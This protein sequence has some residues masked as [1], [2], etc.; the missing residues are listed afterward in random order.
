VG[1]PIDSSLNA[2]SAL[3]EA[4]T[5]A[6]ES[7]SGGA[8]PEVRLR[9]VLALV[10]LAAIADACLYARPGGAGAAVL[11]LATGTG[12]LLLARRRPAFPMLFLLLLP[13][14][15]MLMWNASWLTVLVAAMTILALALKLARADAHVTGII[16]LAP[17]AALAAPIS[18]VDHLARL[19]QGRSGSRTKSAPDQSASPLRIFLIPISVS[20]AFAAI[21]VA[22]NPVLEKVST[23]LWSRVDYCLEP[24]WK[25]VT[26]GRVCSWVGWLLLFALLLRPFMKPSPVGKRAEDGEQVQPPDGWESTRA[27]FA[28]AFGTLVCVNVLFLAFNGMDSIYLYFKADLP[29]GVAWS[30]YAHRGCFWLTLALA[31]STVVIDGIFG[32]SMTFHARSRVLRVGAYVWAFQNLI[33]A[34]G[35]FRRLQM[36]V[37]YNGLTRL[38]VTGICGILLVLTGLGVMVWKVARDRN[39]LWLIRRYLLSSWAALALLALT[40]TDLL[41]WGHNVKQIAGGN[42][43]PLALL[44]NQKTSSEAYPP[45]LDLLDHSEAWI[46]EGIAA[47]LGL[48]CGE[49]SLEESMSWTR[50]QQ[51]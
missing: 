9:D 49:L 25:D 22:A 40:P 30:E 34:V 1:D 4:S 29:E 27:D 45:L 16:K 43:R 31:L 21:F 50:D 51:Y 17:L 35:T 26:F 11:V 32:S 6:E 47:Y 14:A 23:D 36:Y 10:V 2:E 37:N 13:V 41:C 20:V 3:P 33:L 39:F 24:L 18:L 46:R 8:V 42:P 44:T 12:L 7:G 15:A 38:R 28:T 5:L 48:R 19:F